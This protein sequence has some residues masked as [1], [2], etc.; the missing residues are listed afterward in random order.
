MQEL[1]PDRYRRRQIFNVAAILAVVLLVGLAFAL[2]EKIK[3]GVLP[4]NCHM[5]GFTDC[6]VDA[7][8]KPR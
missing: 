6:S 4:Q 8:G 7:F 5:A 3:A 1:P 2:V